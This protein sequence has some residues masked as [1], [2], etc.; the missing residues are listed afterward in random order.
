MVEKS[1]YYF[2]KICS[3][4]FIPFFVM[5]CF[6]KFRPFH[7][8][9]FFQLAKKDLSSIGQTNQKISF[10]KFSGL[11]YPKISLLYIHILHLK[12]SIEWINR[13]LKPKAKEKK[14][15][16][17]VWTI[18]RKIMID[19]KIMKIIC[20][21]FILLTKNCKINYTWFCGLSTSETVRMKH[22]ILEG[23][24]YQEFQVNSFLNHQNLLPH[25]MKILKTI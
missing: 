15:I 23:R 20:D 22:C 16:L 18:L 17:I 9:A 11:L 2:S 1:C 6:I 24:N 25:C 7:S 13:I 21:D 12:R 4:L 5:F 10:W 14:H 8:T 3:R 19:F